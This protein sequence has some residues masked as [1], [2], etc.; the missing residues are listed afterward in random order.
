MIECIDDLYFAKVVDYAL[1]A[2]ILG[3]AGKKDSQILKHK[4]E[5]KIHRE[6]LNSRSN[7]EKNNKMQRVYFVKPFGT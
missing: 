1:I 3:T 2:E 4:E 6:L 7:E 5:R